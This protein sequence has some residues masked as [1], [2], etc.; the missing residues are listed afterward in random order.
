MKQIFTFLF[1]AILASVNAQISVDPGT[2][3]A[4]IS[5]DAKL[6]IPMTVSNTTT[7]SY[8]VF[9]KL[10]KSSDFPTDW[11]TQV[12]DGNLCYGFNLDACPPNKPND[13]GPQHSSSGAWSLKV[14]PKGVKGTGKLHMEFYSDKDF[15][16]KIGTTEVDAM[17]VADNLLN[18][19]KINTDR[20]TLYPNPALYSFS[21]KDDAG[22]AQISLV[23]VIG[24]EVWT[25]KHNKGATYDVSDLNKGIYLVRMFNSNG[26][27][28]KTIRLN[29]T[30]L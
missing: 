21:L 15:T 3:A 18:T 23:S 17:V 16:N 9:W 25:K 20:L 14:D 26:K 24:K 11:A 2:F 5:Q 4:T 6:E 10:V 12:C 29:K 27:I 1:I 7:D 8:Q 19:N 28:I 30:V 22:V 13:F